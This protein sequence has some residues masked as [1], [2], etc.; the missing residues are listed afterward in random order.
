[1]RLGLAPSSVGCMASATQRPLREATTRVVC[2]AP[3][4]FSSALPAAA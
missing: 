3:A 2:M 1:M 4:P